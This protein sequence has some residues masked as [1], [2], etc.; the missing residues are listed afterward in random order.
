[1]GSLTYIPYHEVLLVSPVEPVR[2]RQHHGGGSHVQDPELRGGVG[3]A[4]DV[5]V[6]GVPVQPL[7]VLRDAVVGAVVAGAH[8]LHQQL[9]LP[10]QPFNGSKIGKLND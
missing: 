1:M 10:V 4:G 5:E 6:N 8:V 3:P 7:L 2:P 9:R